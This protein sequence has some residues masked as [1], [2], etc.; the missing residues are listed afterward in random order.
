ML[1]L[2]LES[3]ATAAGA[4]RVHLLAV[5]STPCRRMVERVL[6]FG[7]HDVLTAMETRHDEPHNLLYCILLNTPLVFNGDTG[8]GAEVDWR[9]PPQR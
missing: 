6:N 4:S 9:E 8:L 2:A 7:V 5:F 3:G 1:V